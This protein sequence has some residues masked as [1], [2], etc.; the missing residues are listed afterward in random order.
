[1]D[2]E[3]ALTCEDTHLRFNSVN[4]AGCDLLYISASPYQFC[5]TTS[6]RALSQPL[7]FPFN[8]PQT[9]LPKSPHND[10]LFSSGMNLEAD[11]I[12]RN[13]DD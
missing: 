7:S 12:S 9:R 11:H 8:L 6:T 5:R 3:P 4:Q 13:G 1:M 2:A 10:S